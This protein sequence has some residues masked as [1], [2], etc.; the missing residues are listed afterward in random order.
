MASLHYTYY[1]EITELLINVIVNLYIPA[2]HLQFIMEKKK[3]IQKENKIKANDTPLDE[4]V[5]EHKFKYADKSKKDKD[6][7]IKPSEER[8]IVRIYMNEEIEKLKIVKIDEK[9]FDDYHSPEYKLWFFNTHESKLISK[10][11]NDEE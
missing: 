1:P 10:D 6:I 4:I 11:D 9:K 7:A 8:S 5:E 2:A 3:E